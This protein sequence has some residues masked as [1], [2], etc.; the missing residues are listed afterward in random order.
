MPTPGRRTCSAEGFA[1]T[2]ERRTVRAV[3]AGY[4]VA[5]VVGF[6]FPTVAVGLY[7]AIAVILVV[8]V[9]EVKRL[10]ARNR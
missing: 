7:C 5:I 3:V 1:P 8:P 10:V 2:T 4:G 6:V 9:A